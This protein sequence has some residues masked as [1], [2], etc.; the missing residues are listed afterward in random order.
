MTKPT[1]CPPVYAMFDDSDPRTTDEH[2]RRLDG[3]PDTDPV[4]LTGVVHG[5]PAS[6][7]RVRTVIERVDPTILA[8]EL[9]S[10]AVPLFERYAAEG[11]TPP[12]AGGEM[13]AAI[14]AARTDAVEGID[15]PTL[16]FLRHLART[17]R[18]EE[19]SR[20]TYRLLLRGLGSVTKHA[21]L[22]RLAAAGFPGAARWLP[23]TDAI[24]YGCDWHDAPA[25]QAADE[26][27]QL[28]RVETALNVFGHSGAVRVRDVA[29]EAHMADRLATLRT[30][31][32]VVVVV[33][34]GHLDPIE[35]RLA[36]STRSGKSGAD[37]G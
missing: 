20:S 28:R 16:A 17:L 29:R 37:V 31:G 18:R 7:Y 6:I 34:M 2:I 22:C 4:V 15:A 12:S 13:S 3:P 26:R 14:Q 25:R 27:I 33:G 5:H 24:D 32:S 21:A 10:L 9:P 35:R 8:L 36:S 23:G 11:P 19:A 30:R 1:G